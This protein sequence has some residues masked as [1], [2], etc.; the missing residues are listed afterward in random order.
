MIETK[1]HQHIYFSI[2]IEFCWYVITKKV[3]RE[4]QLY[5]YLKSI[6]DGKIKIDRSLLIE[7]AQNLE[8]KAFQTLRSALKRLIDKNW[9]GYNPKSKNYFIRSFAEVGRLHGFKRKLVAKFEIEDLIELKAF[10][11]GAI[12]G[13]LIR[14]QKRKLKMA[15]RLKGRSFQPFEATASFYP[16]A[17]EALAKI[18]GVSLH[19]AYSYK[20]LAD[21]GGFINVKKNA[22]ELKV[23]LNEIFHFKKAFPEYAAKLR[24]ARLYKDEYI[25]YLQE[26][27]SVKSNVTFA[28]GKKF[29][30]LYKGHK[31]KEP[32]G[33]CI[34]SKY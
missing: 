3:S 21:K 12:V 33:L 11:I 10:L 19:T 18:L 4:A 8:L 28:F 15:E 29:K 31:R 32:E 5:L 14:N 34:K 1:K 2:P 25:T 23:P 6:C 7:I 9:I 24:V 27:D 17:N 20:R 22:R 26:V 30:T 13:D 16:M